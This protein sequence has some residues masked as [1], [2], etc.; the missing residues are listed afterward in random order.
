[1]MWSRQGSSVGRMWDWKLEGL[2]FDAP[3]RHHSFVEIDH[4]VF[5]TVILPL[6]EE[7]VSVMVKEWA[8]S[9]G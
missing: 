8:L 1:M 3:V 4:E 5:S 6:Q 2:R 9:T 7:Q